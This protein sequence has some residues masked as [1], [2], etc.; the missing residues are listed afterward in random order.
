VP[1][2]CPPFLSN[3]TLRKFGK[4]V[5]ALVGFQ[6]FNSEKLRCVNS[7]PCVP[8]CDVPGGFTLR[9]FGAT[10]AGGGA[11]AHAPACAPRPARAL[12]LFNNK[13]YR[14]P[15]S[16]TKSL[17]GNNEKQGLTGR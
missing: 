17:S 1:N 8:G 16:E 9:K 15:K 11:A 7:R 10:S 3:K 6:R 2:S 14:N 5:G 12:T 4:V 13:Q